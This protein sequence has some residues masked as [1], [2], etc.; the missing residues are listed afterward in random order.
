MVGIDPNACPLRAPTDAPTE[1]SESMKLRLLLTWAAAVIALQ[2]MGC[3]SNVST[4]TGGHGGTSSTASTGGT[5]STTTASSGSGG[6]TTGTGGMTA[7]SSGGT[8]GTGGGGVCGALTNCG[9]MCV[10]TQTDAANCG[11]CG[12]ACAMGEMCAA[13]SCA[14]C[15]PPNT[16]CN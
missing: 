1:R 5:A 14:P 15:A 12:K 3:G 2:A 6:A 13:G 10:D 4:G 9:G 11:M 7:S 8:G 16:T